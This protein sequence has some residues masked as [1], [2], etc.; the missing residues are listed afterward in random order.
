MSKVYKV[1]NE[2]KKSVYQT[3][4]YTK[5]ENGERYWIEINQTWRW[6]TVYITLHEGDEPLDA[7]N[8]HGLD[9]D[10]YEWELDFMDD[11]CSLDFNYSDNFPD[12]LKEQVEDG[13]NEMGYEAIENLG[14]DFDDTQ[15]VIHGPLLIEEV[16]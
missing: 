4:Y 5:E 2:E 9:L 7:D 8:P 14:F 10:E 1:Q 6:G 15:Y 11:G 12:E 3:E 16:E 13:W